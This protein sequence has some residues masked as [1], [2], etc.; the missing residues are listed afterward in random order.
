MDER[1]HLHV[2]RADDEKGVAASFHIRS[3]YMKVLP[4]RMDAEVV[5]VYVHRRTPLPLRMD[6]EA[7]VAYV[8]HAGVLT[9]LLPR[10][11]AAGAVKAQAQQCLCEGWTTA[12][13]AD[14]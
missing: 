12:R 7:V 9:S 3:W 2:P 1:Q 8:Q 10:L 14:G 6:A 13:V 4:L 5:V 11:D